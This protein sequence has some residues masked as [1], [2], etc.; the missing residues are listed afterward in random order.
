VDRWQ[1]LIVLG[2]CLVLTLPLE[3]FGKGVYR[4]PRRLAAAVLPVALV[5]LIWDAIAVAADVW[6]Y[7]PRYILGLIG[8][9]DLPLEEL[10][11]F[12]VIPLCGLL[13]YSAVDAMLSVLRRRLQK[14]NQP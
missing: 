7:N 11:F 3:I 14:E 2:A 1:Y 8:P 6:T 5:F 9:G 10:M 4:Q 13:T 12:V